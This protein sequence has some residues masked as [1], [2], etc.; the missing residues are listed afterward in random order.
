M[1]FNIKAF[2]EAISLILT[3]PTVILALGVVR[4][5]WPAFVEALK[6]RKEKGLTANQ[7]FVVGVTISFIGNGLDN[8]FWAIPWTSSYLEGANTDALWNVGVYFNIFFRQTC[9]ILAALCHL[10]AADIHIKDTK[11]NPYI[12]WSWVWGS[13]VAIALIWLRLWKA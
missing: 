8:I 10:K 1:D 3:I 12:K 5:W 4:K 9:G 7:W 6:Q 2:A 11:M 13:I